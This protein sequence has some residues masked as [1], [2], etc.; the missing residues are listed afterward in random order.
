MHAD[1]SG[2]ARANSAVLL[3]APLKTSP[4][5]YPTGSLGRGPRQQMHQITHYSQDSPQ[6]ACSLK[7]NF[8]VRLLPYMGHAMGRSH[9]ML[10]WIW[11]A[12]ADLGDS[13]ICMLGS[14]NSNA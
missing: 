4:V 1:C 13:V 5:W 2:F 12:K 7:P 9:N 10:H 14:W 11:G 3:L 6:Y 8:T